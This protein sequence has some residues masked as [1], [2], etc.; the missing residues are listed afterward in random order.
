M[1]DADAGRLIDKVLSRLKLSPNYHGQSV[2]IAEV[3]REAKPFLDAHMNQ[4]RARFGR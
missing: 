1:S 3:E 4:L 2:F